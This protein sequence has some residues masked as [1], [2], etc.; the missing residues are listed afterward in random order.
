MHTWAAHNEYLRIAVE[1]GQLG[2]ALLIGLFALWCICHARYLRRTDRCIIRLVFIAF[3]CHAFTDNVLI[4]TSASVL[5][6]FISAVFARGRLEAEAAAR[7]TKSPSAPG[8]GRVRGG[9]G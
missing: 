6:A 7:W 2:R 3:A 1:G 9:G 4:S 5:F 8:D